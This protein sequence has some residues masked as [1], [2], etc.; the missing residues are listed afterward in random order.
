MPQKISI[1]DDTLYRWLSQ[2]KK[3]KNL[4]QRCRPER[5]KVLSLKKQ[6]H[7]G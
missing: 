3:S 4:K 6:H 5:S 7:L 1:K 2:L